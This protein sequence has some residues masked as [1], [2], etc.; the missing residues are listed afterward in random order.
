M[1][2]ASGACLTESRERR[3][4]S[5]ER[6]RSGPRARAPLGCVTL[7]VST[8]EPS[9]VETRQVA[10]HLLHRHRALADRGR[11][12]LDRAVPGIA[13]EE[14]A[15]PARLEEVR[16]AVERPGVSNVR[17]GEDE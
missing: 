12:A 8:A 3:Q 16:S 10:V 11:D 2:R 14:H 1:A 13:D 4:I 17:P 7:E 15:G 9:V 6:N 5:V